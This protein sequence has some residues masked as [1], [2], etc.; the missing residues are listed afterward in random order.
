MAKT[1]T[2]SAYVTADAVA[3]S[4]K[5]QGIAFYG[6]FCTSGE[7]IVFVVGQNIFFE[8]ELLDLLAQNK[9]DQGGI[10]ELAERIDTENSK[11]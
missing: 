9:L 4:L 6:P 11:H 10:Q 1:S 5:I 7:R 2:D 8:S 3:N